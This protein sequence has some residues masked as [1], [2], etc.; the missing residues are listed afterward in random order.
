LAVLLS[1]TGRTLRNLLERRARGELRAE[2]VCV[3]SNRSRAPGLRIA[4]DHGIDAR[5]FRLSD[6][7]DRSGRDRSMWEWVHEHRPDL[8]LLAGYLSLLDLGGARG[9]PVLN[10]HPALLPRFGGAGYYGDRVHEAVL[11]AGESRSGCTVHLVDEVYD[12]G[13]ILG[14]RE[15]EVRPQ[16]DVRTLAARVFEAECEL[17]PEVVNAVAEGR[18]E[19]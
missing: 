8:V 9:V 18:I 5:A 13:R 1:G 10:I 12:R 11:A 16:D 7:Q 6:H 14:Q 3:G 19:V 2:I 17:Y 15:V 4:A